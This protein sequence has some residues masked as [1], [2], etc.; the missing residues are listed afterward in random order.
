MRIVHA[1]DLH[2]DSPMRGLARYEGAPAQAMRDATRQ[3]LRNLVDACI[4]ERAELLLLAGDLYDGDW[5]DYSTGLFFLG[6]MARLREPGTRVVLVR[7]N[8]D[9]QSVVRK[10]LRLPDHLRELS[11]DAPETVRFEDLGVAVHGQ[12]FRERAVTDDL[13]RS[14]PPPLPGLLNIGLLHTSADG[15]P[16]HEPYAPTSLPVLLGRGY[17]YW[18]LGHVHAREVLHERPWVVFPGN[19][20]GRHARETGAKGATLI[21]AENG[22]IV[23]VEPLTLDAARW[24]ST[25]VTLEEEDTWDDALERVRAELGGAREQAGDRVL[26]ARVTIS[27]ATSAHRE[28]AKDLERTVGEVRTAGAEVGGVWVEKVLLETRAPIDLDAIALRDDA[29]GALVRAVRSLKAARPEEIAELTKGL[30]ELEQRLPPE[31]RNEGGL[32][33]TSPEVVRRLAADIERT[34]LPK[35]LGDDA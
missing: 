7:G 34:L 5:K 30:A 32:A 20:Q 29:A 18:A 33:L 19:L 31:L 3:A 12:S 1:A 16:G 15:R 28:L 8:H 27:G 21:T 6:E 11:A 13:A 9:A 25:L 35:L 2:I 23:S 24:A 14:Y 4:A 17:D 22:Q 10:A 26:A